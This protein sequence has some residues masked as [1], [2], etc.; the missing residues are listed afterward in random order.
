MIRR[1][2]TDIVK[3]RGKMEMKR[4]KE[5]EKGGETAKAENHK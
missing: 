3:G 1:N 5:T 2:M 4:T